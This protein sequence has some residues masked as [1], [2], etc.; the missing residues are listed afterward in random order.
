MWTTSRKNSIF[1]VHQSLEYYN[2][3]EFDFKISS[4][5]PAGISLR[6]GSI[7]RQTQHVDYYS[8]K[9]IRSYI[10]DDSVSQTWTRNI[11]ILNVLFHWSLESS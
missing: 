8:H 9:W 11:N 1:F 7:Q 4:R 5:L 2:G 3:G 6:Q 10:I